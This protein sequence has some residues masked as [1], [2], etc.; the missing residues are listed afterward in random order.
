MSL[1]VNWA[2]FGTRGPRVPKKAQF[3]HERVKYNVFLSDEPLKGCKSLK[4][5]KISLTF[6][7]DIGENSQILTVSNKKQFNSSILNIQ[8][9]VNY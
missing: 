6:S 9:S 8:K 3:T 1:C 2:F 4:T 7:F 5:F